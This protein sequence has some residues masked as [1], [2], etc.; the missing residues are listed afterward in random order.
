MG[1]FELKVVAV[2]TNYG[3]KL[4]LIRLGFPFCTA[5]GLLNF[6]KLI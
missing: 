5:V 3:G 6:R 2:H 4:R 1:K